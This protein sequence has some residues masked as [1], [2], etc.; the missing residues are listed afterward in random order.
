MS[1]LRHRLTWSITI[2]SAVL[3]LAGPAA[4]APGPGTARPAAG[5]ATSAATGIYDNFNGNS[6]KGASFCMAVGDYSLSG[7]TVGLSERLGPG[8]GVTEPVPSPSHGA[9]VFANE[10]SC[11]SPSSCLFVGDH[12]AGKSGPSANLAEFWNGTLWRVVTDPA[13]VKSG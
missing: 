2:A 3:A 5:A 4:A 1:R 12:W 11:A 13:P 8:G 7:V 9:N 10:V 6:C